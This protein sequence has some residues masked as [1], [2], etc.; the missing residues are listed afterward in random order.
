[1]AI[2]KGWYLYLTSDKKAN[3]LSETRLP[4]C[5]HCQHR[6]K[7][8]NVCNECGCFLPAKTRVKDEQCPHNYW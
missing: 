2:I 3:L 1:M 7:H 6:N 4:V 8:L 5:M